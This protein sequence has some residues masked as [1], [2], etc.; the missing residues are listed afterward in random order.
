MSSETMD[1]YGLEDNL[2]L[3]KNYQYFVSR[4]LVLMSTNVDVQTDIKS[5]QAYSNTRVER[6]VKQILSSTPGVALDTGFYNDDE[7]EKFRLGI[8]FEPENDNLLWFYY[9]NDDDCFY[10][11]YTDY[12][13]NEIAYAGKIYKVTYE[14]ASGIGASFKRIMTINKTKEGNYESR[15]PILLYEENVKVKETEKRKTVQGRRL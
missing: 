11:D 12:A 1:R 10:L 5:G 7:N 15:D 8:A 9:S 4:D 3:F 13:K 2:E 14:Q 6:D